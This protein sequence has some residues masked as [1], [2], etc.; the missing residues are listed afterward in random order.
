MTLCPHK[1]AC[2][3]EA[4]TSG[5]WK[6]I[7]DNHFLKRKAFVKTKSNPTEVLT[8][9]HARWHS[10]RIIRFDNIPRAICILSDGY[11]WGF[12]T[13]SA[14]AFNVSSNLLHKVPK[15]WAK[16]INSTKEWEN[17][18]NSGKFINKGGNQSSRTRIAISNYH[19]MQSNS[20]SQGT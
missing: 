7:Y 17:L 1:Q 5:K 4:V 9:I 19:H 20:H 2:M 14:N 13:L 12:E 15:I 6:H 11:K 16:N 18:I 3:Q 8:F 10:F